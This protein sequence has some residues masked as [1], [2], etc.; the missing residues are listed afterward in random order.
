[1]DKLQGEVMAQYFLSCPAPGC[2]ETL[3]K[4]MKPALF[5]AGVPCPKCSAMM[6]RSGE[7]PSYAVMERLD[8]GAMSKAVERI[9]NV[10]EETHKRGKGGQEKKWSSNI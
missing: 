10:E 8:N 3:R 6:V 9:S 1:M 5:K 2:G 7:P 4:I